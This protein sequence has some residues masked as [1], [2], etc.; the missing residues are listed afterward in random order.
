MK[1]LKIKKILKDSFGLAELIKSRFCRFN[2][3]GISKCSSFIESK[4]KDPAETKPP[5]LEIKLFIL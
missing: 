2:S 5:T 4:N 1:K 3:T